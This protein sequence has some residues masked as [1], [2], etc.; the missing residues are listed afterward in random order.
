MSKKSDMFYFENFLSVSQ[1]CC[2]AADY[3][4]ECLKNYNVSNLEDEISHMHKY[5][6]E[7]DIKKHEMSRSLSKAFIT[8]LE[9]ED[10]AELSHTLDDVTDNIE[11]VLQLIYMEEPQEV[12]NESVVM[13]V[14]IA[15]CCRAMERMFKELHNFNKPEKLLGAI[16][17]L[18]DLEEECDLL[19]LQAYKKI[20]K[21]KTDALEIIFWRKVYDY[22]ERCADSCEHVADIVDMI[23]M[24]NS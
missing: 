20:R 16:V 19:Y 24:K 22:L 8:P 18:N 15:S 12:T 23:V 4:V 1:L 9:R 7:A 13:A 6:H 17:E 2:N 3:L 11:E 14:K 10:L 5:E 21:E